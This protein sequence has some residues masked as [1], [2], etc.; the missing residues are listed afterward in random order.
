MTESSTGIPTNF[1]PWLEIWY[2][3]RTTIRRIVQ[4][5]PKRGVYVLAAATGYVQYLGRASAQIMG[6]NM[7]LLGILGL[8]LILGPLGGIV[9]LGISTFAI[10]LVSRRLG[11]EAE[12]DDTLAAL[13]WGQA[14]AFI[15][16]ALWILQ[17]LIFQGDVFKSEIPMVEANPSLGL[18]FIP[19]VAAG[20]LVAIG[21]FVLTVLTVAEVNRFSIWRSIASIVLG[22]LVI[23]LPFVLCFTLLPLMM[24]R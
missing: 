5:Y 17:L 9:S 15:S 21:Q 19:I 8:G 7:D 22:G 1:N 2:R 6:D 23:F 20:V 14:P 13:A 16:L 24:Q 3:P 10:N 4:W 18:I 12:S 11:G